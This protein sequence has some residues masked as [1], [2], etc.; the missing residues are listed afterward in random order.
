MK[1]L[2]GTTLALFLVG[3][4][5]YAQEPDKDKPKDEPKKEE[6]KKNEAPKKG[7]QEEPREKPKQ[8]PD[9]RPEDHAKPAQQNDHAQ[10]QQQQERNRSEQKVQQDRAQEQQRAQQTQ[11]HTDRNNNARENHAENH[12]NVRR[13]PEEKYRVNFGREHHFH[14]QRSND[15]RFQ[16]SGFWFTYSD[17]WPGDWDYNDDV[18]IEEIDGEYYMFNPRHP[19][20]RILVIVAD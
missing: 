20:I 6:P 10:Q 8:E 12:G 5:A 15:R 18:Y 16:Y 11:Q 9:R 3:A 4:P 13:I 2:L 17:P 19:G 14:V 7:K 1:L